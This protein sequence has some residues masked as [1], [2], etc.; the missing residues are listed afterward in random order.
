[1]VTVHSAMVPRGDSVFVTGGAAGA[2]PPSHRS[3]SGLDSVLR[4]PAPQSAVTIVAT[5]ARRSRGQTR[6]ISRELSAQS[7]GTICRCSPSRARSRLRGRTDF[8]KRQPATAKKRRHDSP[9]TR[10]PSR[11]TRPGTHQSQTEDDEAETQEFGVPGASATFRNNWSD[12]AILGLRGITIPPPPQT[13]RSAA[14]SGSR[15]KPRTDSR[16]EPARS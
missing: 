10:Y 16:R 6:V 9:P 15:A 13:T 14:Q 12:A 3:R 2:S 7:P 4:S 5:L 1:M 8:P 11:E